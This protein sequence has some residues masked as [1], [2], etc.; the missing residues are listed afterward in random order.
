MSSLSL[1]E[2]CFYSLD[3]LKKKKKEKVNYILSWQRF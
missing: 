3:E 2:Q 1:E